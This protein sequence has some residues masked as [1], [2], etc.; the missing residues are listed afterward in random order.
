MKIFL[1]GQKYFGWLVFN[2]LRD[3]KHEIVGVAAPV[4]HGS[5]PDRLWRAATN[6][7]VPVVIPGGT[8]TVDNLPEGVDLIICAHSYDFVGLKTL[9]KAKLGGI[10]YHPSLL[11]LHRG[12]DAV[13][14]TIKMGDRITGGTVY[15]L[16]KTVDGGPVAA[17]EWCFVRPEWDA[18]QLWREKLQ[19]MGIRL[20]AK[21]LSDIQSGRIVAIPQEKGLATWEPS[22]D[23]QPIFRPDLPRIG[24]IEGYE[25]IASKEALEDDF[26]VSRHWKVLAGG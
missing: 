13:R 8:L 18:T 5:E 15:W 23:T 26:G 25:V 6:L 11:P 20:I 4:K 22:M 3:L 19:G 7:D 10:G 16:N 1:C 12:R 9:A 2:L 17:Q 24:A 14:W 21:T